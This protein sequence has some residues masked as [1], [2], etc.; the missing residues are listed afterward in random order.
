MRVRVLCF[1]MLR[2]V[3]GA[4]FKLDLPSGSSVAR[5]IERCEERA[6]QLSTMWPRIA[7]AVN[8]AYVSR[9]TGLVDGDEVALLPP[10]S[11]GAVS[12]V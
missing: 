12:I 2:D 10:V 9:E 8:Q 11:G 4:E 5:V 1:G 7:V 6:P 3:L